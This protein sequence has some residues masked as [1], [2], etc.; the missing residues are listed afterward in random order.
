MGDLR[1]LN[2]E[3]VAEILQFTVT[4]V[5]RLSREGRIKSIKIGKEI[6]FTAQDVKDYIEE[7]RR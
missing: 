6:R 7:H 1:L 3:Q 5:R 4:H 2:T